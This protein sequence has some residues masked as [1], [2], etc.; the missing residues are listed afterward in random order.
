MRIE[1]AWNAYF[2]QYQIMDR[3]YIQR[4]AGLS[5][6]S[7][8]GRGKQLQVDFRTCNSISRITRLHIRRLRQACLS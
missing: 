6:Q 2:M 7:K 1:C 5:Y 4:E 3:V 8:L